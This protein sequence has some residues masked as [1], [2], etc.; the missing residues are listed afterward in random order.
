M[1]SCYRRA[2]RLWWH[3]FQPEISIF[4]CFT[5]SLG[6]LWGLSTVLESFYL[7]S[8]DIS[9]RHIRGFFLLYSI[10]LVINVPLLGSL[11]AGPRLAVAELFESEGDRIKHR[12]VFSKKENLEF[13]LLLSLPIILLGIIAGFRGI[14]WTIAIGLM[15]GQA[16]M[17][18]IL[19]SGF[20]IALVR[21]R[22]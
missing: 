20:L 16:I 18:S 4:L 8:F 12:S 6:F 11:V 13:L 3:A 9:S 14:F 5:V 17:L 22:R 21:Y 10:N 7:E 15:L 19:L 1:S 2:C